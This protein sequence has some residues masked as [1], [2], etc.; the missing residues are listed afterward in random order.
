MTG[1]RVLHLDRPR[2]GGLIGRCA[3]LVVRLTGW[4]VLVVDPMP[5][6]CVVVFYPHTSNWDLALGLLSKWIMDLRFKVLVK[7]TIPLARWLAPWSIP[8]NRRARTGA[9]AALAARFAEEEELRLVIAPEGTR[10]RTEH[11][12]SGFYRLALDAQLPLALSFVDYARRETGIGACFVPTGNRDA[13]MRTIAAFY[14]DK[15]ARHPAQAGPVRL[16]G[17]DPC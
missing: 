15:T 13:D 3:S 6:R 10:S 7:D 17:E 5:R 1:A 14:A 8:I 4:R 12:K 2:G 9:T 16:A 11:W